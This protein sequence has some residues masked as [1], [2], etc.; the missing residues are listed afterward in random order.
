M[1]TLCVIA[2]PRSRSHSVT[3]ANVAAESFGGE[4][5]TLDLT[6]AYVPFLSEAVI[7]L[8]YGYGTYEA[9][10]PE[11]KKIADAQSAFIAQLKS[12]DNL[13]I[14][15]PLWNFGVPASLKAWFDLVVKVRDTF[16]MEGG[17]YKGLIDTVKS[18]VVVS[19]RGGKYAGTAYE[20]YD[21]L[22]K[23]VTGLLGFIGITNVKT[24]L[25]EG[26][27]ML[28]AAGL[29]AEVSTVSEKIR[30]ELAA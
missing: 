6:K 12:A 5:E 10:S 19:A 21:L 16:S 23:T 4:V 3:L 7:A 22:P 14:A 17:A 1:K 13:V 15:A 18:A 29:E 9:L 30:T 27:N 26:V 11:D 28:D 24:Y 20:P 25:L 2:S 8:N